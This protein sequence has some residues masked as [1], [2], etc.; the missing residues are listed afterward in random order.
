MR[1]SQ[2]TSE[3]HSDISLLRSQIAQLDLDV[4][5]KPQSIQLNSEEKGPENKN[6]S[7]FASFKTL[8]QAKL[9]DLNQ[10]L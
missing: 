6:T 8:E 7:D 5:F 9:K 2:K 1:Q 3:V 4:R 10:N